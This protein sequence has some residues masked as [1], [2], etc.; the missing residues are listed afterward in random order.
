MAVRYLR[1]Q[2][3]PAGQPLVTVAGAAGKRRQLFGAGLAVAAHPDLLPG[4]CG[5]P[6]EDDQLREPLALTRGWPR[7]AAAAARACFSDRW[8]SLDGAQVVG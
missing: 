5:H 8:V 2:R 6:G 1:L 7:L 3:H 4:H